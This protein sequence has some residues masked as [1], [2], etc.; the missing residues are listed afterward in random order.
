MTFIS[1][2]TLTMTWFLY[3]PVLCSSLLIIPAMMVDKD[4]MCSFSSFSSFLLT[5]SRLT[6]SPQRFDPWPSPPPFKSHVQPSQNNVS[7]VS[8]PHV[9]LCLR[10]YVS[11]CRGVCECVRWERVSCIK[12]KVEPEAW[13]LN[14]CFQFKK[15]AIWYEGCKSCQLSRSQKL[16]AG[17][18]VCLGLNFL[19]SIFIFLNLYYVFVF[20]NEK[21]HFTI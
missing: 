7:I 1:A 8:K 5:Q 20:F 3:T 9:F 13:V 18:I 16:I 19:F 2:I 10:R 12:P 14:W 6:V 4:K 21:F 11:V 17:F 15:E